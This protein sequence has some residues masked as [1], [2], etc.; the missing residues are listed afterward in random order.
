MGLTKSAALE[1]AKSNIRINAVAPSV[2]DH[3]EINRNMNYKYIAIVA[4]IVAALVGV[5]AVTA[6]S[7]YATKYDKNQALSQA[8][9][10]GN[11][12]LP[13]N[14]GCQNIASQI[15]GDENAVSLG[16]AQAFPSFDDDNG[17]K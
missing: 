9:A 15:Q 6:D 16:A 12:E 2:I 10:C 7:A 14:I 5:T 13:L 1:Y 17:D 4:V 3:S 11:G 8:N